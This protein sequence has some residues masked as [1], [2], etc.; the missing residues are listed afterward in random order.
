MI[1][2]EGE[3]RLNEIEAGSE[4]VP[5]D[6]M[7]IAYHRAKNLGVGDIFSYRDTSKK[8]GPPAT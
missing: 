3:A 4:N 7:I 8:H 1:H 6:A 5:I 2:P